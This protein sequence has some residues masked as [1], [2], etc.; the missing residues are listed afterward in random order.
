MEDNEMVIKYEFINGEK[1]EIEVSSDL[2]NTI[3]QIESEIIKSNR[4]ET[5]RHQSISEILDK[6]DMLIDPNINVEEEILKRFASYKLH[7][8]ISKLKPK[9][10]ELIHKLYLDKQTMSQA[11]YAKSLGVTENSIKQSAK[12][13]KKKLRKLF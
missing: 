13:I 6:S 7:E 5:M 3:V 12:W 4:R 8:A 9:E 10:Q 1:F 11:E 2:S